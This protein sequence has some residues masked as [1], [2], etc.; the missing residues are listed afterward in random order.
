VQGDKAY[1]QAVKA[2]EKYPGNALYTSELRMAEPKHMLLVTGSYAGATL[3]VVLAS[4][5]L[6]LASIL[7]RQRSTSGPS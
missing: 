6:G 4:I 7:A 3:G 5:C 2:L 1:Y